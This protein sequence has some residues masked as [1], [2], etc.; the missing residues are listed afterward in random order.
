MPFLFTCDVTSGP[1]VVAPPP[2]LFTSRDCD[3]TSRSSTS[4]LTTYA[5]C[6]YTVGRKSTTN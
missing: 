3:V 2:C 1:E 5:V 6:I 4:M